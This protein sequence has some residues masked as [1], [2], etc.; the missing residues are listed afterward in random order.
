MYMELVKGTRLH[1]HPQCCI[2]LFIGPKNAFLYVL[3]N[4]TN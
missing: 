4:Y 3:E 2:F 1:I